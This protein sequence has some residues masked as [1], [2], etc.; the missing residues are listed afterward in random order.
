MHI[1]HVISSYGPANVGNEIHGELARAI[2]ARGH[3]YSVLT[4]ARHDAPPGL[5]I[6]DDN[7]ITVYELGQGRNLLARLERVVSNRL[8]HYPPF[9]F[10]L[11]S[12]GQVM[13]SHLRDVD[14]VLVE[15]GYPFGAMAALWQPLMRRALVIVL[16][17]GDM[18]REDSAHYGFGRFALARF[19]L[20]LT[21]QQ[22]TLMRAYSPLGRDAALE[23]G[24]DPARVRVVA[25][26]IG[27]VCYVPDSED[28]DSFRQAA[29]RAVAA[30]HQLHGPHLLVA[31]GRL[32]P[33]KGFDGLIRILPDIERMTGERVELILCGP[34]RSLPGIGDYL[35]YLEHLATDLGIRDRISFT[36]EL[37]HTAVREY[38]AAAD[39]LV[40]PSV[41]EGGAK[42]VMEAAAVGTP[43][44]ATETAGT[45]AFLPDCGFI[46][47]PIAHAPQ[48]F[49]RAVSVLL[50]NHDLRLRLGQRARERSPEFNAESRAEALLPLYEEAHQRSRSLC[51]IAYPTSLTLQS[52]NALQTYTTLRELRT[53]RPNTLALI[54]RWGKGISRFAEVGAYHLPRPAVGRFS[55][56]YRS[57]L[58]YYLEYSLFA[59]MCAPIVAVH[60]V[61]AIYVRQNI[62]AA[63]WSSVLGPLLGIPV[64]YEA[65]DIEL[66]N[67]SRAKEPWAE[68]FVHM[69][70][71]VALTRASAV[72]SLTDEFRRY[73]HAITW[74]TMDEVVVIPDAYDDQIFAPQ[75]KATCRTALG[76][77]NDADILVYAGMTFAHRW[78]DGLLDASVPLL[79]EYP[80]LLLVLVGGRP[81]EIEQLQQQADA[82]GLGKHVVLTGPRPQ[83]DVV[84]Y[85]GAA[86]A[87]VMPDT[88][89]DTTASPLKL[90]EYLALGQPLVLP[91]LPA[92]REIVPTTY[93]CYFPRRDRDGLRQA[94]QAALAIKN[95]QSAYIQRRAIAAEHTY[96]RR[97]ERILNVVDSIS[98][99]RSQD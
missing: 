77:P 30:R 85:M 69:I 65:H 39:M 12:Y 14:L 91:D 50:R 32:L 90:F 74:R 97:A 38:L 95:N 18:H 13:R 45:P 66:R 26:N 84:Q 64:I 34:G 37:A 54:A 61:S 83:A 42:V 33:I 43:F 41:M 21:L 72:V 71:R 11:R 93:G 55:R 86:D 78:L 68:G 36:G 98:A 6:W 40:V 56:F 57:S 81:A 24:A 20:R 25:Q 79:E 44:V 28:T 47:P 2:I 51:Y 15:G 35:A 76:L 3:R 27:E 62:C 4:L 73:L 89:S 67:P 8:F 80:R 46:V 17:G 9:L 52:A 94:I 70:D 1:L 75:D 10:A 5:H 16:Q 22:A 96:G 58:W 82:L 19:L 92:L 23:R 63:W 53:R 29:R 60:N 49:P 31:V 48:T 7:G 99:L 87:F 88:V 59:W